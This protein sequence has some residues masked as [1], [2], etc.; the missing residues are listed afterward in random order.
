MASPFNPSDATPEL[1]DRLNATADRWPEAIAVDTNQPIAR[2][3]EAAYCQVMAGPPQ[4]NS[5]PSP[6]RIEPFSLAEETIELFLAR[7]K[8]FE[9]SV[10]IGS[11]RTERER[12]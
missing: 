4:P 5:A 1:V 9:V 10:D 2:S 8:R 7:V 11:A 3:V 12:R 6:I